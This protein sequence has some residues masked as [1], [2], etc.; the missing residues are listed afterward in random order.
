MSKTSHSDGMPITGVTLYDNGYAVFR[1]EATVQGHGGVDLYFHP[2]QMNRVLESLQFHG[3]AGKKVGNIAYEATKPSASVPL[4]ESSPFVSVIRSLIGRIA[5]IE[6]NKPGLEQKSV[7]GRILGV[8]ELFDEE[9]SREKKVEHVCLLQEGGVMTA[10]SFSRI[11]SV[12][13]VE[14][15]VQQDLSFSLDLFQGQNK[16]EMQKLTVFYSNVDT[17]QTLIARY[18]FEIKEWKSSYRI[19]LSDDNEFHLSGLAVVENNLDEDWH[20]IA[21]TLVVGAPPLQSSTSQDNQGMWELTVKSLD[22]STVKVR[23]NPKDSVISVKNKVAK[24]A[25]IAAGSFRLVFAGKTID[26]G[27]VLSDYT[28]GNYATLH[29][30]KHEGRSET[31]TTDP[32]SGRFVMASQD[33]L[34]YYPIPMRVTA[35][36]KQKAIVPLLE[37]KLEGQKVVLY[38]ET[39][40]KGNPLCSILFENTTGRTLE[41]GSVQMSSGE[42]FLGNGM[43][44]TIHPGDESPPIPYAIELGCEVVKS[45]D[46]SYLRPHQ[47]EIDDGTL[48]V[49]R[50]HR[51]RTIYRIK[52]STEKQ[53]DFLLNHLFLENYDLVQNTEVEEEEPVDI[54]DR[55][56]QFRFVVP[57]KTEKLVFNVRE[58]STDRKAHN[59]CGLN[60]EQV[61]Y[62]AKK[63]LLDAETERALRETFQMRKQID[64]VTK[65]IYDKEAEIREINETQGRLQS[66]ITALERHEKEAA[67]YIKSLAAEEDKRK[68][69]QE[70]IK[71]NRKKKKSL[72]DGLLQKIMAIKAVKAIEKK[73]DAE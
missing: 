3:E 34:S 56:Y 48:A 72:E 64:A 27:R 57:P 37:A 69:L 18:G 26:D 6:V 58:E 16:S 43:L 2:L 71:T 29:M 47:L 67:K 53:F 44:P 42:F 66:T 32:E 17:P 19:A 7:Q 68:V 24:K 54:T 51:E 41:G 10:V 55:F 28:V 60:D 9:V 14:S 12:C 23:V 33:N 39:I 70:A 1:R 50:I 36:R 21:L 62:W 20:D 31:T 65:S 30:T 59:I 4:N 13:A 46:S 61:D 40:R 63:N 49:Y 38:D 22:G 11:Q 52:N 8:Q 5:L 15:Q 45:S 35:L 73:T 25:H